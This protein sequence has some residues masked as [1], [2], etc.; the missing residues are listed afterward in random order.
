MKHSKI[1]PKCYSPKAR[2]TYTS[3]LVILNRLMEASQN[4]D[5]VKAKKIFMELYKFYGSLN[6]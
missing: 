4:K 2:W 3:E 1:C 5:V 6:K